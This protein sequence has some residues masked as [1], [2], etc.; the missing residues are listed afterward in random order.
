[1][2]CCCNGWPVLRFPSYVQSSCTVQWFAHQLYFVP[3][4]AYIAHVR[5][6]ENMLYQSMLA[7]SFQDPPFCLFQSYAK[8]PFFSP[9]KGFHVGTCIFMALAH[10]HLL[11][12]KCHDDLA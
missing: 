4:T 8:K 7:N 12:V 10:H 2:I 1:M 9:E 5:K 6:V 3:I 11:H